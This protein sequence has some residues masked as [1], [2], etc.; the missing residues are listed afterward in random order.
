[1][2]SV[3][4]IRALSAADAPRLAD[5]ATAYRRAMSGPAE[6]TTPGQAAALIERALRAPDLLLLG[7]DCGGALAGFALAFELPEIISGGRAGQLDDLFVM[8]EARGSGLARA[9][10]RQLTEIGT[11]RGWTH[12]RWLVPQ[13]N[14]TAIQL[15]R[16]I[17][18]PAPW[19]SFRIDLSRG[20][21]E[22]PSARNRRP[23][24]CVEKR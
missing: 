12:L 21:D 13:E 17:A 22:G 6:A 7:A 14:A 5:L 23:A 3:P 8:P 1:M 24:A 11:A 19:D 10:I 16:S 2:V 4:T 20:A 18:D 15:Y 9:L